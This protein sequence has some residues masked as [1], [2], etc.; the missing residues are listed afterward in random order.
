MLEIDKKHYKGI[1]IY[2]TR[3]IVI[4]KIGDCKDIHSVNPLYLLVNHVSGHIDQKNGNKCLIFNDLVNEKKG[5]LKICR[6]LG[7]N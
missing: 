7:W 5:L 2:Y 4:E 6:C 1:D 3:Y